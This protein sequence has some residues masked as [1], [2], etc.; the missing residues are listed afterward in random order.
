MVRALA[1]DRGAVRL[2]KD[3]WLWALGSTPWD[4][5][6]RGEGRSRTVGL[7][8][9][10]DGTVKVLHAKAGDSLRVEQKILEFA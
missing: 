4:M 9:T 3:E 1:A 10:R 5:A 8:A 7:R 2:T 6:A